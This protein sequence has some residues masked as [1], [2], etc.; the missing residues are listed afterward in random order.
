MRLTIEDFQRLINEA[1]AEHNPAQYECYVK[2]K[3]EKYLA[4]RIVRA[5]SPR[6]AEL[7]AIKICRFTFGQPSAN[8]AA[9]S[10]IS[11]PKTAMQGWPK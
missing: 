11:N 3:R 10:M 5:R 8:H 6:R 1:P 9:V 2:D 4:K 7:L